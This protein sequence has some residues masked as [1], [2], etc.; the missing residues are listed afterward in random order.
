[1]SAFLDS[2]Q[3]FVSPVLVAVALIGYDQLVRPHPE[4]YRPPLAAAAQQYRDTLPDAYHKAA[5]QVR[6]AV[7]TDKAGVVE[8]L[9]AHARPLATALDT[10][11]APLI[12]AATGKITNAPSA[13]DVLDQAAQALGGK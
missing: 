5:E 2:I 1:M 12:D 3:P 4:P 8:A 6:A 9:K 11:F 7:L 13:A 10:T